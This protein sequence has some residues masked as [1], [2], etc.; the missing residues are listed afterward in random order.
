MRPVDHRQKLHIVNPL[1]SARQS[2]E[3]SH[4][5]NGTDFFSGDD[6]AGK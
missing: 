2:S 4:K 5:T 6:L 1:Q 3:L